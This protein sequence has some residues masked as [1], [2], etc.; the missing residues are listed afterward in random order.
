VAERLSAFGFTSRWH[1]GLNV[2][3]V[4]STAMMTLVPHKQLKRVLLIV[5]SLFAVDLSLPLIGDKEAC[6]AAFEALWPCGCPVSIDYLATI[7]GGK[8]RTYKW[9]N[10]DIP[11]VKDSATTDK[12]PIYLQDAVP[13]SVVHR[14]WNAVPEGP[15]RPENLLAALPDGIAPVVAA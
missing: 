10:L 9:N 7:I 13:A 2:T 15:M 4:D 1:L 3:V 14:R 5:N 6:D 12:R 8:A 11:Y